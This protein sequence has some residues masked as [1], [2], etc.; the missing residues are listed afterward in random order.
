M[1]MPRLVV[2]GHARQG[3]YNSPHVSWPLTT[4][5]CDLQF[6]AIALLVVATAL[7]YSLVLRPAVLA[8]TSP[9]LLLCCTVAEMQLILVA[10]LRVRVP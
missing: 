10:L 4:L 5:L 6:G 3:P 1:V 7:L 8:Q 9:L 2:M